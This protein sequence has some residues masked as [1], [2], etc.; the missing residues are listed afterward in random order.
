[1]L[2]TTIAHYRITARLGQGGM[3]E[4]YRATDAKL[5]REVAIKVL[6]AS[7]AN[8]RERVARFEREAK[9]LAQLNHP[10]IAAVYDFDQCDG[11][12]FLAMEL[13]EGEDLSQRLNRGALPME[14]ALDVCR[15]IAEALVAAHE[16]GIIHRD[17]KPANV[18]LTEEGQAKVLDFGLAKAVDTEVGRSPYQVDDSPAITADYTL[19]GTLLGTAAYMS[20]EQARGKPNNVNSPMKKLTTRISSDSWPS[21]TPGDPIRTSILAWWPRHI[22]R[23][24]R[25]VRPMRWRC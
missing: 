14:E 9:A 6:P 7:F 5:D 25:I 21:T 2:G 18:K 15:Q 23:S 20:P 16:K 24:R 3:G 11:K 17:L 12:W 19:P 8:E 13:V 22:A 4:V 10:H 1:M